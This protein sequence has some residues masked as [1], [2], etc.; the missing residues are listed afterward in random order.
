MAAYSLSV[1]IR[2]SY[3]SSGSAR[4]SRMEHDRRASKWLPSG[5]TLNAT[6][7][8]GNVKRRCVYVGVLENPR[9]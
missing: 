6:W 4:I 1:R 8:I 3:V 7:R 9:R 5:R 2:N